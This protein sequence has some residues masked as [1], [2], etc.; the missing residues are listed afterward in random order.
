MASVRECR[1]PLLII[2][3]SPLGASGH[4]PVD[5]AE[6]RSWWCYF[7]HRGCLSP[8][9][10]R[11]GFIPPLPHCPS[12]GSLLAIDDLL[13]GR[14][15]NSS[16]RCGRS[17]SSSGTYFLFPPCC[18]G[19]INAGPDA[20]WLGEKVC[21]R[22]QMATAALELGNTTLPTAQTT[23]A[24]RQSCLAVLALGFRSV[25]LQLLD[26]VRCADSLCFPC[27]FRRQPIPAREVVR[28]GRPRGPR[29]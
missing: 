3:A 16:L 12:R 26:A 14:I 27:A 29:P 17:K 24:G 23:E 1:R 5:S 6:P 18:Q 2:F 25:S 19:A 13:A 28:T 4:V 8:L 11:M 22:L 9:C 20:L 15:A 10:L 21:Q 7:L